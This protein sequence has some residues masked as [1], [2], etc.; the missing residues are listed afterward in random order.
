MQRISIMNLPETAGF[1]A[2]SRG[3]TQST[4]YF[5]APDSRREYDSK[6]PDEG[7]DAAVDQF[8]WQTHAGQQVKRAAL[9]GRWLGRSLRKRRAGNCF[10]R[11]SA[12]VRRPSLVLATG[13]RSA[14]RPPA[15]TPKAEGMG[16]PGL[17]RAGA[18]LRKQPGAECNRMLFCV[19]PAA[20]RNLVTPDA[21]GE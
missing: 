7:L 15:G 4:A 12:D 20:G 11:G 9:K 10:L 2:R 3:L 16:R 5:V 18:C 13:R 1:P 6:K 17:S 19:A 14:S 8:S 21:G